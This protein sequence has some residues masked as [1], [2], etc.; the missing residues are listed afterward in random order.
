M[1]VS[2]HPLSPLAEA[3]APFRGT[4]ELREEMLMRSG[5]RLSLATLEAPDAMELVDLDDPQTLAAEAMRP[6]EVATR[7]RTRTQ[8]Q[9]ADLHAGHPGAG[10]LRWW[11]TLES[12][13]LNVTLF[14]RALGELE[15]V[16]VRPLGLGDPLVD[17]AAGVLG[18]AG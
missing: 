10:G 18:L 12:L 2:E 13:W 5:N 17:E 15:V 4:G 11:S 9:A 8:L 1:Y 3:L 6:S 16:D 7:D 14:D